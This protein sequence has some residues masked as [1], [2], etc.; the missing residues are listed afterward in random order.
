MPR[1]NSDFAL[2][3]L[4]PGISKC[5]TTTLCALLNRHPRVFIPEE[6]EPLLFIHADY[7]EKLDWYREL[8]LDAPPN[9]LCGEGST[10]YSSNRLEEA[11][12][13]RIIEFNPDIKLIFIARDPVDRI[14]SSFREFHHSGPFFGVY[15]PFDLDAALTA[16][17]DILEDCRYWSRIDNYRQRMPDRNILVLLLE[18]LKA[19]PDQVLGRCFRFLGLDPCAAG[20]VPPLRLNEGENKLRDTRAMR[21]LRIMPVIGRRVSALPLD[22]QNRVGTWFGLRKPAVEAIDWSAHAR[23]LVYRTLRDEVRLFL[24]DIGRSP[25][26]WPRF[27]GLRREAGV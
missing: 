14:E 13:D 7:E 17:P 2:D 11:S 18:D 4:V 9:A 8:F 12:R 5:G 27:D 22:K 21:I 24:R 19:K 3:F 6:K 1:E 26:I 15:P 23:E 10:F 25:D 16:L 20:H